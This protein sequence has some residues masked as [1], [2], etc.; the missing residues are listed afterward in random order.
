MTIQI[1]ASLL[2]SDLTRLADEIGLLEKAGVDALHLDVMDGHFVPNLTFGLP[3]IEQIRKKT[4]L[5]LDAHLMISNPDSYIDEYAKVG[6]DWISVHVEVCPHLNRTL[7]RIREL[8]KKAGVAI[9]PGTPLSSLDAC[10]NDLDYILVMSVNPGFGGQGFIPSALDKVK[11]LKKKLAGTSILIEMDGGIKEH[12]IG[13]ISAAGVD[14]AVVGT[15]LF[16]S[17]DYGAMVKTLK[18][19]T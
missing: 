17:K 9:N 7:G 2:A 8:K 11:E 16:Q 1:A 6:C 10:L 14:V 5:T 13:E 3:V 15:G 12:N 19:K 4:K 18:G